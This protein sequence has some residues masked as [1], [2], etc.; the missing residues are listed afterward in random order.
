ML[1]FKTVTKAVL[2]RDLF[3]YHTLI[4]K[5]GQVIFDK[6]DEISGD[7][8]TENMYFLLLTELWDEREVVIEH[9][10]QFD[11]YIDFKLDLIRKEAVVLKLEKLAT[12][13]SLADENIDLT[14]LKQREITHLNS[15]IINNI[16]QDSKDEALITNY[17]KNHNFK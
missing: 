7:S 8:N 5:Y 17:K 6:L 13:P 1:K 10:S 2:N 3:K 15:L 9:I 12:S 14:I 16:L 11:D 4:N